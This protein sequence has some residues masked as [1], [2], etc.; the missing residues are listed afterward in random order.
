MSLVSPGVSV[1]VTDRS[2]YIPA[3]ASTVPLIF[4]ATR[5]HKFQPDGVSIADGTTEHSLVRT[6]TSIGQSVALYGIPHFN[7]SNTGPGNTPVQ[8]HGDA[9][10]EYGLFAMNQFLG[11]GSRAFFVRANID[12]TDAPEIFYSPGI[13]QVIDPVGGVRAGTGTISAI[14]IPTAF[15]KP[16]TFT[17]VAVGPQVGGST[18]QSF[19]VT[20]SLS[21]MVGIAVAGQPFV[22]SAVHFLIE[23]DTILPATPFYPGDYFQFTSV[24]QPNTYVGVG[25]GTMHNLVPGSTLNHAQTFTVTFTSPTAFTV[26]SSVSGILSP[27]VVGTPYADVADSINFTIIA[28]TTPFALGDEFTV[29]FTQIEVFNK[30][31]LTDADKRLA[32]VTALSA[33]I[34][35]NQDVRSEA[36]EYNLIL[37]PGYHEVVDE[38]L[39]LSDTIGNEAF[40]IGDTP[41]NKT[42]EQ[43]ANWANTSEKRGSPDVA[44]YYPW[45]LASNLDGTNVTI[46]PAGI[47]LRT[48]AISD[49]NSY[50][51]FAPAGVRRGV[52]TGV[53]QVGYVSGTLGTPTK[54]VE[55]NLNQGQRD[56]LYEFFK[57]INPIVYFPGR[58]LLVWGQKTAAPAASARDRVNVERL[59][60]HIR[61]SLRKS[62]FP[63]VFEIND[64]ITRDDLKLMVDG[65]LHDILSLR[66]LY[67]FV[68]ICDASNNTP[69]RIDR[70]EMWI[71]IALKPA[72]VSEFIY[73][74]ITI[75]STG[76]TFGTN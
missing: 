49:N 30:L 58:G 75:Y 52:V 6:I 47:A 67:D 31:G 21:G 12:L 64:Q 62:I 22:N 15:K 18:A 24:Y 5:A 42:P 37:C 26:T 4:G 60:A 33:E 44:Y 13:P 14:S 34:N 11:V 35:S 59:L 74:P 73:A 20:G 43:T 38:M 72:K 70:N 23:E 71:D 57:N 56:N 28:G 32:I 1:P 29:I 66:G 45:G 63:F 54:F 25:N 16:E 48:Y 65:F 51:W 9:R 68:T 17:V 7:S 39:A 19:A 10:N 61:R 40:V 41:V 46:S 69:T 50:V 2:F 36:F 8:H 55:A 53:S 27:G 76:A 3:S